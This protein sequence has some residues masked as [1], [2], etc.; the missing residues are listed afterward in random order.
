S[1]QDIWSFYFAAYGVSAE[2]QAEMSE[3]VIRSLAADRP[4]NAL[5]IFIGRAIGLSPDIVDRAFRNDPYVAEIIAHEVSHFFWGSISRTAQ[6]EFLVIL[7]QPKYAD[8]A[9]EI[10]P[11]DENLIDERI[12]GEAYAG[13][14]ARLSQLRALG[15]VSNEDRAVFEKFYPWV[16]P[17]YFTMALGQ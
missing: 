11:R 7:R 10:F 13:F 9:K 14:Y 12:A 15:L 1:A 6:D 3:L 5:A 4:G 17:D 8:L 2:T 16:N